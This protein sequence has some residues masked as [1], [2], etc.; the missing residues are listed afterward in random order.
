MLIVLLGSLS[1]AVFVAVANKSRADRWRSRSVQLQANAAALNVVVIRRTQVLNARIHQLDAM[2]AKVKRSQT[3]LSQSEGDV[4]SLEQR[5]RQLANDKAQLEDERVALTDVAS[6]YIT[7]KDD[8]Q[9]AV[10][11]IADQDWV[12]IDTYAPQ[13]NSDCDT[14]D[15]S[16]QGFLSAYPGG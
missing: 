16:L 5:Q 10:Q 13:V 15:T 11:A 6:N 7:C 9:N 12:W 1:V 14:A 4:Q 8:L 2:A 3:A